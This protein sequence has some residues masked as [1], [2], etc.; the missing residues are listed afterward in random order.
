MHSLKFL[1]NKKKISFPRS[2][3]LQSKAADPALSLHYRKAFFFLYAAQAKNHSACDY[4]TH[5][6]LVRDCLCRATPSQAAKPATKSRR[7]TSLLGQQ[8]FRAQALCGAWH[9]IDCPLVRIRTQ[10]PNNTRRNQNKTNKTKQQRQK[11][12]KK[13]RKT[14][15]KS[16]ASTPTGTGRTQFM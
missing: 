1:S 12:K 6:R 8:K 14:K 9:T 2:I 16:D 3:N 7:R 11:Q 10:R 5:S 13:K 4:A 15:H